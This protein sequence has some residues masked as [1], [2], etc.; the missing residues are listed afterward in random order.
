MVVSAVVAAAQGTKSNHQQ[1]NV[2]FIIADDMNT[3]L[4]CY[5]HPTVLTPNIDK[6]ARRGIQFNNAYCNYPVCNPSR[7]S[8]LSGLRP[9]TIGV[10]DNKTPIE[11]KLGDRIT[12]PH[13]FR[14]NGYRTVSLGKIFHNGRTFNDIKAWDEIYTFETTAAGRK[15]EERNITDGVI[16]WCRWR[17]AEGT[18]EDQP[19]GQIADKAVTFIKSA[20]ESPFFLAVGF[21]KPHDPFIAP[22]KYFDLYPLTVCDP[23]DVPLG[24]NPPYDHTLPGQTVT[25]NKFTERDK[26]EFLR[27]YYACTSFLDAQVG[28]VIDA[29]ED[30]KLMDNTVIVFL[31]DHGYHL[32]EHRWWNKV[33][34]YEKGQRAPLIIV[35]NDYQNRAVESNAM[36]EF[37]DIYPTFADLCDLKQVPAYLQGRSFVRILENPL[38]PFRDVV[39]A[40]VTRGKMM[41][42]TVKTMDWRYTEWDGGNAGAELYDQKNDPLEYVNLA[43]DAEYSTVRKLMKALLDEHNPQP[44]KTLH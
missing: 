26:R 40:I 23:P 17:A 30:A 8:M 6:L 21:H 22:K 5:D 38:V 33:T 24:W 41:G 19:D 10:L 3:T 42:R 43:D 39:S 25:F 7:S 11:S 12:L 36:I 20:H 15:G 27:A 2:V 31:G 4:G 16:P 35:D 32:G 1:K 44:H 37:I 13:L 18:D 34:V 29:L 28:K 14:K 9:E